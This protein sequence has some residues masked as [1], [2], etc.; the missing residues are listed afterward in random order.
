M[1]GRNPFK[2]ITAAAITSATQDV[3]QETIDFVR[4]VTA[5]TDSGLPG[6][7]LGKERLVVAQPAMTVEARSADSTR[8]TMS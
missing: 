7:A 2:P 6:V 1:C 5:V 4:Q 8:R 3:L